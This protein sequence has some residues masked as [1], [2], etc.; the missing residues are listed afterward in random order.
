MLIHHAS[1]TVAG[2]KSPAC[3]LYSF[4]VSS[5][6]LSF[7]PYCGLLGRIH[8]R[9][10]IYCLEI[11][12]SVVAVE[13]LEECALYTNPSIYIFSVLHQRER[14]AQRIFR[15]SSFYWHK[16]M[17]VEVSWKPCISQSFYLLLCVCVCVWG[18][19]GG[20]ECMFLAFSKLLL[21]LHHAWR[22]NDQQNGLHSGL[23]VLMNFSQSKILSKSCNCFI[24]SL[25]LL[26]KLF[27]IDYFL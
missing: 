18:G 13:S 15:S 9:R 2:Y 11:L 17:G 3:L 19:G 8:R 12:P 14:E 7:L 26:P 20:G 6:Y 24:T 4:P 25:H 5:F 21:T 23:K 16:T 1:I 10:H 27:S 22:S